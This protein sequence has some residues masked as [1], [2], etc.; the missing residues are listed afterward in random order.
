MTAAPDHTPLHGRR[1]TQPVTHVP[2]LTVAGH[3]GWRPATDD[4]AAAMARAYDWQRQRDSELVKVVRPVPAIVGP[5]RPLPPLE[6][7]LEP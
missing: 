5:P 3:I 1:V 4:E 2:G 6:W 7:E